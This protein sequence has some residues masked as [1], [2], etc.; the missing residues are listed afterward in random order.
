[1]Q[2]NQVSDTAGKFVAA[3]SLGTFTTNIS[4]YGTI[5]GFVFRDTDADGVKDSTETT[6]S[7]AWRVYIDADK[8]GVFDS[9]ERNVYASAG[10]SSY[11]FGTLLPGTYRVRMVPLSG[12]RFTVPT[13]GYYDVTINENSFSG[14]N[15]GVT[16]N[17]L[18][19]GNVF[20]DLN[21]DKL[22]STGELGLSN[23][24]VYIDADK[25]GIFDSTETSV[26]TDSS[27]NFSFK[28]KAAGT[29]VIRIVQQSGWTRT[30]T[31][32]SYT[33]TLGSG[34][35]SSTLLFGEKRIV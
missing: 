25:D 22:K 17:V 7:N 9:T 20:N 1:M 4:R 13:S 8:D 27:G 26:L 28:N 14:K 3:G 23:W 12:N 33:V 6:L 24:R 29:Y 31:A 15:F 11:S 21:G 16:T 32:S 5:S 2:A 19:K 35:T 18:I 30:T 10:G 34:G